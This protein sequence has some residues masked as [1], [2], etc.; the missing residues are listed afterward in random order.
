[1]MMWKIVRALEA[2]ILYIYIYIHIHIDYLGF[3]LFVAH[4]APT[5]Y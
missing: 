3:N 2:S 4:G 5:I 1:M